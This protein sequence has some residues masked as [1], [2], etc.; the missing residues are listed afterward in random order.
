MFLLRT[1]AG[2]VWRSVMGRPSESA[3]RIQATDG[4]I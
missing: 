4:S 3:S 1:A 2:E